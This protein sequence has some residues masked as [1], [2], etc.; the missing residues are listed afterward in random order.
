MAKRDYAKE[1]DEY[2]SKPAQI[3]KRAKRN[4]ARAQVQKKRAATGKP[5]LTKDQVVDH[6]KTP[7][8][9]GGGNTAGNLKVASRKKNAG[10][11]K[12]KTG[13]DTK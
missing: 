10:W 9:K 7:I 2:H 4:A 8:R 11:R 6:A 3:K 12:G 5:P 1:Y 13:Y